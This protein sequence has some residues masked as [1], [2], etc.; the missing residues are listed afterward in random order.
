V[1]WGPDHRNVERLSPHQPTMTTHKRKS[2][3]STANLYNQLTEQQWETIGLKDG[4]IAAQ[5][6][7]AAIVEQLSSILECRLADVV[8][9]R[10]TREK[11][12]QPNTDG[13]LAS[14]L[15]PVCRNQIRQFVS[16]IGGLY[17][18]VNYHKFEHAA[19][20][21]IS[22]NKLIDMLDERGS[23]SSKKGR[24]RS[25]T[26]GIANDAF[27]K[28]AVVFSALIHDVEHQ[29]VPN[30][31][32]CI[33]GDALAILYN[34]K[35]VAEQHSIHVG[36]STLQN[37]IFSSFM[38]TIVPHPEDK[39]EFRRLVIDI[40]LA[41]DIASQERQELFHSKWKEAFPSRAS[42]N[43]AM[44]RHSVGTPL[45][46]FYEEN[47][48]LGMK[49]TLHVNCAT[50]EFNN[51]NENKTIAEEMLRVNVVLDLIINAADVAH[52][53]QSW[54]NFVIWN[55]NLYRELHEAYRNGRGESDPG[56]EWF[57]NQIGFYDFY[58]LPLARR[59][60]KCGVF[61]EKLGQQFVTNAKAIRRRWLEEGMATSR[62]ILKDGEAHYHRRMHQIRGGNS[63][64]IADTDDD[65]QTE[66]NKSFS[67]SGNRISASSIAS[68]DH[69]QAACFPEKTTYIHSGSEDK[70]RIDGCSFIP[71]EEL[72]QTNCDITAIQAT[73]ASYPR[74]KTA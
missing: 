65:T 74:A 2:R 66:R 61:G 38:S 31:Q 4:P 30:R 15:T 73:G 19:H 72:C 56:P 52:T 68:E 18:D 45:P 41:T 39:I 42:N 57:R 26:F 50:I 49:S 37:P 32:L 23:G 24:V 47:N 44:R 64:I 3:S 33:E 53:M 1:A 55:A 63:S 6:D 22:A 12:K 13:H 51:A 71:R 59:L 70:K 7:T 28:F 60:R 34:D 27:A 10:R 67:H 5:T 25:T 48:Q 17:R 9:Q 40:V 16:C 69:P 36:F 35:S 62:E 14:A 8:M 29:G 54:E 21:T 20:V 46:P 11:I 58:V 43:P